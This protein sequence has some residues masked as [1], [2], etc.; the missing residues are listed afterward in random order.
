MIFITS[1]CFNLMSDGLRAA[2]D[3]RMSRGRRDTVIRSSIA[4][5]RPSPLLLAREPDASISRWAAASRPR[6]QGRCARSTT[7]PCRCAKGETL[8]IVGESG[9]GKSTVA[10]LLMHLIK[11]DS[12]S[13]VL[14]R[15]SGRRAARHHGAA[16]CAA[17]CRWCSRIPTPRSTRGCTVAETLA[18]GPRCTACRRP[19]PREARARPAEQGRARS[20][21][22]RRRAI[23]TS[24]PAASASASTSPARWRSS[25]AW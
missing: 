25:R 12:G 6:P 9:C 13:M 10:R 24:C 1:I 8:G 14:R 18:F 16:S 11:P 23:R 20:R 4:A 21:H 5:A 3:V 15:R 17:R 7:S 2:M 22:L 19:K